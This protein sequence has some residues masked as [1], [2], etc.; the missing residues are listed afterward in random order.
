MGKQKKKKKVGH[1]FFYQNLK[2]KLSCCTT[3]IED[4]QNVYVL[5]NDCATKSN[6][7]ILTINVKK[8]STQIDSITNIYDK[9]YQDTDVCKGKKR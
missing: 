8:T 4:F 5:C 1:Y 6:C 9:K 3:R 2:I 7:W